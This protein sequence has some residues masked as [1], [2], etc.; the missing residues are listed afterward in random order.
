MIDF[1]IPRS[2]AEMNIALPSIEKA[3]TKEESFWTRTVDL[4]FLVGLNIREILP[5]LVP[6]QLRQAVKEYNYIDIFATFVCSAAVGVVFPH[7]TGRRGFYFYPEDKHDSALFLPVQIFSFVYRDIYY[8]T[9]RDRILLYQK[10]I[11]HLDWRNTNIALG[12][13]DGSARVRIGYTR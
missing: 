6:D 8:F 12:N 5:E 13:S 11:P 2:K 3:Q 10:N 9:L 7:D 1:K 4:G